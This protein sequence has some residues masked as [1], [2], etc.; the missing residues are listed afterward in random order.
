MAPSLMLGVADVL[1]CLGYQKKTRAHLAVEVN[2]PLREISINYPASIFSAVQA[3]RFAELLSKTISELIENAGQRLCDLNLLPATDARNIAAWN[4]RDLGSY[5]VCLHNEICK[6]VEELPESPAICAWDGDLTYRQ[7]DVLSSRVAWKLHEVGVDP[8][9]STVAFLFRKSK[10]SAV[11]LLGILKAGA[12]AVALNHDHP[13]ERHRYILQTTGAIVLLVG[14]DLEDSLE[15]PLD[16]SLTKL[17][18]YD[19]LFDSDLSEPDRAGTFVS[20]SVKPEDAAYIQFTSGSSGTPKGIIMEHRTYM[21]NAI[22]QIEAYHINKE[23]RVLQFA[24]H[25]F[26]AFLT[27]VVTTLLAGA[28]VCIPSEESRFNDLSGAISDFQVNWMGMTPTL[29][30][31]LTP[32]NAPTLK[33]LATWGEVTSDDIIEA[34]ADEVDLFNLYGPSE[35]SVGA[36]AHLLSK[37]I[38]DPSHLGKPIKA[39]NAWIVRI[40]NRERLA[41]IGTVGELALQ[42]P[43]VAR[44]YLQNDTLNAD[45][46]RNCIPWMKNEARH[47][48]IYYT[49]DL[50]RYIADGSLEFLG[51]RDTQV[52]IRGHRIELGEIEYHINQ[53]LCGSNFGS[54]VEIVYPLYRQ[55][56]PMLIAFLDARSDCITMPTHDLLLPASDRSR[57][58]ATEIEEYL[59]K[60]LPTHFIPS[61]YLPLAY[62]PT[63]ASGKADRKLLKAA[64]ELLSESDFLTYSSQA[65]PKTAPQTEIEAKVAS[66]WADLLG[67]EVNNIGREDSFFWLGGNSILAMRFAVAARSEGLQ[68]TVAEVLSNPRLNQISDILAKQNQHP[69]PDGSPLYEPFSAL[70]ISLGKDFISKTV[71]PRLGVDVNDI[72]DAALATDYQIENLAWS[73]L[74]TRGGTNYI[75]FDFS[76]TGVTAVNL[77]EALERLILYHDILRTVYLVFKRK[78]YQVTLKQ[79][80]VDIIHCMYTKDVSQATSDVVEADTPMPVEISRSLLKFWLI[81]GLDGRVQRMVMRASH[82]QYDGVSLIRLCRELGSAF[83]GQELYPTTSF[84][85]YSHFA[86]THSEDSARAFWS[87][88]LAGS[89]MTSIFRHT[90]I[91]WK[92]VLDGQVDIMIDTSAVRSDSEITIGT[93]IKAAWSLVLAEMSGSDDVVFGSVIWGRNAMYPGIEHVAG[94]CIDN[95]PVRVRLG[96]NMTRRQLLEQIQGQY[97]EAVSFENFQYKRI[98]EECTDWR[99]WERLST[100]VEYENLG[101]ETTSF[102]LDETQRFTVD[103]IRPPADRHD[104][105]IFSTPVGPEK[106]FIALDFCKDTIPESLAQK[107]L[108]RMLEHI[109]GFHDNIDDPLQLATADIMKLPSIPMLLP[110]TVSQSDMDPVRLQSSHAVIFSSQEFRESQKLFVEEAWAD[111]LG[112]QPEQ[113]AIYWTER[114][115]FYNVWGNL[116]AAFGIS[117][118]YQGNGIS[119]SMEQVL[120]NPDMQSQAALLINIA[121]S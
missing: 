85:A 80:S 65:K 27:E 36:T 50:V 29:A 118:R 98:V 114:T 6:R 103:E 108:T 107:M 53:V 111:A 70:P 110:D 43:T 71:A 119:V 76:T 21:A 84:F 37:G 2:L 33:T 57:A 47:Q 40:D 16:R 5:D 78:V 73:S 22:S 12:A 7:L 82:L 23:S 4:D 90:S 41:P 74:K 75:T 63:N 49:G 112:C 121:S 1:C 18:V 30:R 62:I 79:L 101:E 15:I 55:C 66:L 28:C 54:V 10:W 31:T 105:T 72:Q 11:C 61:L 109:R 9:S 91:P 99:P 24:S 39:V 52:K 48:R 32:K 94:A 92:Y 8:G 51:R 100:L 115:P 120:E 102:K 64:C 56:Q 58:R 68:V 42:G 35:N 17:A 77:Q 88:T 97:F 19:S 113:L 20:T 44:G 87:K 104:I 117:K 3:R 34:W 116:I 95:I 14:K 25:S 93:I 106:T 26:D 60:R 67:V 38:R 59:T 83:H 89:A 69:Q 46:F 86:A 96:D 13:E 81:R 45:S